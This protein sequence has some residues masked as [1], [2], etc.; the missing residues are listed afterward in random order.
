ML[1]PPPDPLMT[2]S[3]RI[4]YIRTSPADRPDDL[5]QFAWLDV[6]ETFTDSLVTPDDHRRPQRRAALAQLRAGDTLLVPSMDRIARTFEELKDLLEDLNRRGVAV[7]FVS[8][9][10]TFNP[11]DSDSRDREIALLRAG[12][13][14]VL[15]GNKERQRIGIRKATAKARSYNGRPA[16]LSARDMNDLMN[17]LRAL[18]RN[19]A[20]NI[21]KIAQHY[22]ISRQTVYNYEKAG[23]ALL[24]ATQK[25][26][27]A[28]GQQSRGDTETAKRTEKDA[29]VKRRAAIAAT[30]G[31]SV[32]EVR[33]MR[34]AEV[35][36][37][38]SH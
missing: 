22:G 8:E 17:R 6:R 37:E 26:R 14:F 15:E 18:P 3:R 25:A 9:A 31:L 28:K 38:E 29:I 7:E 10:L 33:A 34:D 12:H 24:A 19:P 4:A 11:C 36:E 21:T 35:P 2:E 5:H 30:K 27:R 23:P 32:A 13:R 16:K 20:D 1:L